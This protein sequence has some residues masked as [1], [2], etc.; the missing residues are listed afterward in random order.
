MSMI[1]IKIPQLFWVLRISECY[2]PGIIFFTCLLEVQNKKTV[3]WGDSLSLSQ[4][5]DVT[6]VDILI[7]KI[8]IIVI[9]FRYFPNQ[10]S[11]LSISLLLQWF[12]VGV[13]YPIL[14]SFWFLY[15]HIVIFFVR[16]TIF[17]AFDIFFALLSF[18]NLILFIRFKGY[19][20]SYGQCYSCFELL[21]LIFLSLFS[22]SSL[23]L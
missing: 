14:F 6:L 21:F 10:I 15:T 17:W 16:P 9:W 1:Y 20:Y 19:F 12:M 11:F 5:I 22:L 7:S 3:A 13:L 4:K 23:S 2:Y 8:F 18:L